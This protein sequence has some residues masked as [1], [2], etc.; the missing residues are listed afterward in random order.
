[1]LTR[2]SPRLL[3]IIVEQSEVDSVW[4]LSDCAECEWRTARL[5]LERLERNGLVS[6]R[7]GSRGRIQARP[8]ERGRMLAQIMRD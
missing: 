5:S 7:R 3:A 8:T 4:D 2:S 6:L 1:M